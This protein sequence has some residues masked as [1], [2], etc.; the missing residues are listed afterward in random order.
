MEDIARLGLEVVSGSVVES[1]KH[2][3]RMTAAAAKAERAALGLGTGSRKGGADAEAALLRTDRAAQKAADGLQ[4]AEGASD[5][6][7]RT[8]TRLIAGLSVAAGIATLANFA[9]TWSDLNARVGI[10]VRSMQMAPE[11][12]DRLQVMARRTYSAIET[13][14]NAFINN[15]TALR[16]LGYTTQQQL[17]FTEALNNALVVSGAKAER[18]TS[19]QN[20]LSKAM[21]LGTLQGENLNTVIQVGGRV[22]EALADSMGTTVNQLRRLGAEGKITSRDL[23]GITTQLE[24]LREEAESMPATIADGFMLLR[25]ATLQLVGVYDQAN[26]LSESFAISLV[27]VADNLE[28]VARLAVVAGT[29]LLAAFGAR[30]AAAIAANIGQLVALEMALGATTVRAALLGVGIKQIQAAWIGMTAALAANPL[31][32]LL[33]TFTALGTAAY[34][35]RDQIRPVAEEAATAGDYMRA[36]WEDLSDLVDATASSINSVATET[37][38]AVERSLSQIGVLFDAAETRANSLA[39]ILRALPGI[40]PIAGA[41]AS[42]AGGYTASLRSRAN[43]IAETRATVE[44]L[45]KAFA[46]FTEMVNQ[47]AAA[48]ETLTKKKQDLRKAAADQLVAIEA[49]VKGLKAIAAGYAQT[50]EAGLRAQAMHQARMAALKNEFVNVKALTDALIEQAKAEQNLAATQALALEKQATAIAQARAQAAMISDPSLRRAREIEIERMEHRNRLEREYAL[51]LERVPELMREWDMQKAYDEQARFWDDVR[52]KAE[53]ISGDISQFLVDGFVNAERGGQSAFKNLWDGAMAG[54]KR[55]I[56][57]MAAEFLK[58]RIIMPVVMSVVGGAAGAFGIAGPGG[59]LPG[60]AANIVQGGGGMFGGLGSLGSLF[61]G[62]LSSSFLTGIGLDIA[63]SG[64]G[65]ALG[66]SMAMPKGG[67]MV[68]GLGANFAG[69]LG[70]LPYAGIGG[71][72]GGM[73]GLTSGNMAI[74]LG[75]SAAGGIGGSMLGATL[76]A[77][78]G[79]IGAIVGGLVG[80]LASS[81]FGGKPSNKFAMTQIDTRGGTL[82]NPIFDPKERSQATIDASQQIAAAFLEAAQALQNLTGGT[83]RAGAYIVAGERDGFQAY[84]GGPNA[85][86]GNAQQRQFSDPEAA[87]QWMIAEFAKGMWGIKDQDYKTIIDRGSS[88]EEIIGGLDFVTQL[89]ALVK[90]GTPQTVSDMFEAVREKW[91]ALIATAAELGVST[92]AAIAARRREIEAI[93]AQ[94]QAQRQ[95]F[96]QGLRLREMALDG[97][98]RGALRLTLNIERNAQLAAAQELVDQQILTAKQFNRLSGILDKEIIKSLSDFDAAVKASAQAANDNEARFRLGFYQESIA[99]GSNIL[100]FLDRQALSDASSL[101]PLRKFEESQRQYEAARAS[102]LSAIEG[103]ELVDTGR[104]TS[105]AQTFLASVFE[106]YASTPM[107]A[108]FEQ[109]V[110]G[111]LAALGSELT[112]DRYVMER[113][114]ASVRATGSENVKALEEG[115]EKLKEVNERLLREFTLL[116]E[117]IAA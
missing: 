92:D 52:K 31:G 107:A 117:Q 76:G 8:A 15:S 48:V 111:D 99:A 73:L 18:A 49:E 100:Q 24:K 103:G 21:A 61:S 113:I 74:D 110:R 101:S 65:A 94:R 60:V 44:G 35:F 64:I 75:L 1:E 78:G 83:G 11:V 19:V 50:T 105:S 45:E 12:M 39:T 63:N 37:S 53:D 86:F 14:T 90:E 80:S 54:V 2:L 34:V 96:N 71:L 32:A 36:A 28:L 62:G 72:L 77:A 89:K 9:D 40:G 55:F 10:A 109:T 6:L 30:L 51:T 106:R 87:L 59:G 108:Q 7:W 13:T 104:L 66:L 114:D 42:A 47:N 57:N 41:L 25:N 70:N 112:S 20:A 85:S 22:A 23:F 69:A 4:R 56:A 17:D 67:S 58:A 93:E 82:G 5:R 88:A 115:F 46:G 81:L 95:S 3:D 16:E 43:E 116:R 68:T 29:A 91:N 26:G 97:N 38:S 98:D 102:A 27:A 33:I 79:P 84:V